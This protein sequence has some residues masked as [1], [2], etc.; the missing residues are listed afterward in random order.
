M[1]IGAGPY[2]YSQ[3]QYTA[4]ELDTEEEEQLLEETINKIWTSE[5]SLFKAFA[6]TSPVSYMKHICLQIL[7]LS[8][9]RFLVGKKIKR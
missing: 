1:E 2:I 6:S 7:I 5:E 9:K 4:V 8:Y 3:E